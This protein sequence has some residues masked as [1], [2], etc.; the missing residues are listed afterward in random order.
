VYVLAPG[1][2][3]RRGYAEANISL[4]VSTVVKHLVKGTFRIVLYNHLFQLPYIAVILTPVILV[5]AIFHEKVPQRI[6]DLDLKKALFR[7]VLLYLGAL[8]VH[9]FIMYF[10]LGDAG[11]SPRTRLLLH[12]IFCVFFAGIYFLLG[13]RYRDKLQHAFVPFFIM[14]FTGCLLFVYKLFH[15]VPV[16]RTYAQAYDRQTEMI[17]D[18]KR[19]FQNKPIGTL[20]LPP[21]PPSQGRIYTDPTFGEFRQIGPSAYFCSIPNGSIHNSVIAKRR[22]K[23]MDTIIDVYREDHINI[24]LENTFHLPFRI[25]LDTT[26]YH[27]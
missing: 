23:A 27:P 3:V 25:D 10:A 24:K 16:D 22:P 4:A 21:L 15:E 17:L 8:F 11:G 18:A 12:L 26:Q 6:K 5:A 20:Y 14:L 19:N 2:Y 9:T 1:N 13:L 7:L